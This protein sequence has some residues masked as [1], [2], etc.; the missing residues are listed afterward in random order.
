MQSLQYVQSLQP[1]QSVQ[2]VQYV[3]P[4]QFVQFVQRSSSGVMTAIGAALKSS[5]LM[6]RIAATSAP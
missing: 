1:L 5:A 2:H 6:A 3:Q 4:I